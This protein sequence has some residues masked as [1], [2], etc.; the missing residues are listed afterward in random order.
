MSVAWGTVQQTACVI[1]LMYNGFLVVGTIAY[2]VSGMELFDSICHTMCSLSTG[3]FSTKLNSIGEYNNLAIEIIT[4][5]L[6]L[7]G[8]TNF[9]A[10]LLLTR[11][12]WKKFFSV[13]EVRFM[14]GL[15]IIFIPVTAISLSDK[16]GISYIEGLRKSAFDVVSALSTSG[17]SSMS[18]ARWPSFAIGVLILMMVIGGGVGSTAGGIKLTRVYLMLK[19]ALLNLYRR[20]SPSRR[21][22]FPTYTKPQGKAVID[23]SLVSDTASFIAAYLA[24]YIL[25]SLL[26]TVT[27]GCGLMEGMFEF[28]SALSTVGLSIGL[29]NPATNNATLIVEILGMLIGRLEIFI[30]IIAIYSGGSVLKKKFGSRLLKEIDRKH[31]RSK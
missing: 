11:R 7:I 18:Y 14:F 22:A 25:G 12:K 16:L 28:A 6:M 17:Y 31:M 2:C 8:T 1:F 15:L 4:I 21:V 5:V 29:T 9:A 10:L 20:L 19:I 23:A 26:L 27:A 24:L 30:V 3:G 13:S